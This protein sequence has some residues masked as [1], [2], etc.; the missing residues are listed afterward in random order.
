MTNS[1]LSGPIAPYRN[2]PIQPQF[3]Q[4]SVFQITDVILGTTTLIET[5]PEFTNYVIGQIVRL[6][7]P[8]GYGCRQ[9]NGII[10]NVIGFTVEGSQQ[11]PIKNVKNIP[12]DGSLLYSTN[13]ITSDIAKLYPDATLLPSSILFIVG[14]ASPAQRGTYRDDGS[15]NMMQISGIYPI[16]SGTIDYT[17][18]TMTLNFINSPPSNLQ[19][20]SSYTIIT[21]VTSNAI[22]LNIDSSQNV[23]E[24]IDADLSNTPQI[25]AIGDVNSG[26]INNLGPKNVSPA[27]PGSFINISPL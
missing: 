5:D 4:P 15:G 22:I 13:I 26:A 16:S 25:L 7:I 14:S 1:F 21:N 18:S 2:V 23:D 9:L 12:T 19:C 8:E 11:I 24:F 6:I 17:T 20:G 27:I 3:Y 10:G